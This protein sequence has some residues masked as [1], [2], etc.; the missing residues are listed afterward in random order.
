MWHTSSLGLFPYETWNDRS[1]YCGSYEAAMNLF[2]YKGTDSRT[3]GWTDPQ[4]GA[5]RLL[6]SIN[7]GVFLPVWLWVLCGSKCPCT[8]ESTQVIEPCVQLSMYGLFV[9]TKNTSA[10]VFWYR[11][12]SCGY[13]VSCAAT[14]KPIATWVKRH[15]NLWFKLNTGHHFAGPSSVHT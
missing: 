5:L 15:Q 4:N 11:W 8:D 13:F 1:Q 3:D 2:I 14:H 10:A 6:Q 7:L 12:S 9:H